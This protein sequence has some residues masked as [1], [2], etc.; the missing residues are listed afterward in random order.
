MTVTNALYP[1]ERSSNGT[2]SMWRVV[3]DPN[4]NLQFLII[5][6]VSSLL[7]AFLVCIHFVHWLTWRASL[8]EKPGK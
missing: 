5:G 6:G 1:L 3:S 4:A 8:A 2:M 7:S